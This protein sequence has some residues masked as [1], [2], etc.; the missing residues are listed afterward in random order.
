MANIEYNPEYGFSLIEKRV[1]E[2]VR[3]ISQMKADEMITEE[4][5]LALF[6]GLKGIADVCKNNKPSEEARLAAINGR[7]ISF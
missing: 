3:T 7:G 6:N 4:V 5:A 1:D 2:L